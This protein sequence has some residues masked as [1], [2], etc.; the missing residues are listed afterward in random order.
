MLYSYGAYPNGVAYLFGYILI[1]GFTFLICR[2]IIAKNGTFDYL[3]ELFLRYHPDHDLHELKRATA[4]A[5]ESGAG[6]D[7]PF[8]FL[9]RSKATEGGAAVKDEEQPLADKEEDAED[10][11][12]DDA[13]ELLED[14][15]LVENKLDQ[16]VES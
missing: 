16:N 1:L 6:M 12:E 9:K 15:L 8:E 5:Y 10:D 13:E 7:G 14:K 11:V 4:D 3:T 2:P